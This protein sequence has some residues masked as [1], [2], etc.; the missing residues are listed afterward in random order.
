MLVVGLKI[1]RDQSFEIVNLIFIYMKLSDINSLTVKA[2][3]ET[4]RKYHDNFKD[5][6]NQ[7]EY[8]R[9]VLDKYSKVLNNEGLI[10]DAGCG[11]SGHIGKYLYR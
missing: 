1:V 6:M 4:A 9:F 10:C 5:E 11:P 2:Y 8:D 7:K 3:K